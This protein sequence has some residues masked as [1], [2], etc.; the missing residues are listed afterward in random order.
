MERER[1]ELFHFNLSPTEV[2]RPLGDTYY[3]GLIHT[4]CKL[5]SA[6]TE[7]RFTRAHPHIWHFVFEKNF[8]W[9]S[10]WRDAQ[11]NI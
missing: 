9:V 7:V 11:R 4:P 6:N 2:N 3:L 8:T 1:R 10:I 5:F